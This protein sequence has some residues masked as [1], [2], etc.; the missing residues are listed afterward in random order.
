MKVLIIGAAGMIGRKFTARLVRDGTLGGRAVTH[1]HF[2]DIVAPQAPANAP[3]PVAIDAFDIAAPYVAP[4]LVAAR[5]DVIFL[6]ASVVSGEAEA[7]FDKSGDEEPA[8][9]IDHEALGSVRTRL[10]EIEE[11]LTPAMLDDL[12]D[13]RNDVRKALEAND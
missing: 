10:E 6:L 11:S 3:F 5:P 9:G 12:V 1:A 4:K 13:W 8:E 2:V 7:D